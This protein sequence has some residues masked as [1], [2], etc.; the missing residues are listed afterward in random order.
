MSKIK[1][2]FQRVCRIDYGRLFRTIRQTADVSGRSRIGIAFDMLRCAIRYTAAPADYALFEFW[3]LTPA[4]RKT[5]VTRGVNDRLVKKYNDRSLWHIF[6]NKA[7][8][9][10]RYAAYVGR[11]WMQLAP[12]GFEAFDAFCSRHSCIF[13]KPLSLSCGWGIEK[14]DVASVPD[15]H[16]LFERLVQKEGGGLIEEQIVQHPEMNRMFPG[17]VNTIRLVTI[18]DGQDVTV[19][20]SFLRVGNGKFVDNL[21][22]GGMAAPI[23]PATGVVTHPAADKDYKAYDC[24]PATGTPFVGFQ[25]PRFAEAVALVKEAATLEPRMGYIGWDIA[26]TP[27]GLCLVEANSF[28]GHD[29]LQLPPHVPDKIGLMSRIE[30]F[31]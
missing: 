2:L 25:I 19:V 31:L 4:Q 18:N 29:I 8:F 27:D 30:R 10:T 24:H 16:A 20:F 1:Y 3:A 11:D 9:N 7:E 13:Y 14:I 17:S 28:P 23:D 6:D 12:D 26:V 22:S 21:N 15:R 5:Y